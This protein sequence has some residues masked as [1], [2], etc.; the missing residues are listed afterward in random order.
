MNINEMIFVL[1]YYAPQS[2]DPELPHSKHSF[3]LLIFS[4]SQFHI[5]CD[6]Q[7]L[8]EYNNKEAERKCKKN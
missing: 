6:I 7:C 8:F 5:K 2:K 3:P 4:F 1:C